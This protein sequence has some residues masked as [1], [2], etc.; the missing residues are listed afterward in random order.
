[1]YSWSRKKNPGSIERRQRNGERERERQGACCGHSPPDPTEN[2]ITSPGIGERV[3]SSALLEEE[4]GSGR[5]SGKTHISAVLE[6]ALE[7]CDSKKNGGTVQVL[8]RWQGQLLDCSY[9]PQEFSQAIV[10][11]FPTCDI[12][13]I[14][15]RDIS[16][17]GFYIYFNLEEG[18]TQWRRSDLLLILYALLFTL[19]RICAAYG[20]HVARLWAACTAAWRSSSASS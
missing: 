18:S 11:R 2:N 10:T 5:R 19:S 12:T 1:M 20:W 16:S 3:T 15:A 9:W 4:D 8:S 14:S 7:L 6:Y 17:A 13:F